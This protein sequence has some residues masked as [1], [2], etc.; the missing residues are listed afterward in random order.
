MDPEIVER[1]NEQ[2]R[3]MADILSQQ[4]ASMAAMVKNMQD[5]ATAAKNQTNATKASGEAFEGVT[6][7]Q[8]AYQQVE[9]RKNQQTERANQTIQRF[10]DAVD[11]TAGAVMTL[12]KT[13]M[14]SNHSFQKYNGILGSVGDTALEVGRN[15]GILGSILGGVVKASTAVLGYQ[16]E[17]ADALLKFNDNISK[18]G[19]AN[20][21]STDTIL[22]MGNAAGFVAKDLEKLSG[23]MQ[24]LGSNFRAIGQG[25]VDSTT[26]FMEMVNVGSEVRQEF[27]RLGYSQEQLVEA[28]AGYIE[29]MGTAGL[30]LRSF[31][32]DFGSLSK[33][34]TDYVKNLQVLSELSGL[35]VEEQQ[36]RMQA[37]AADRQFQLY[38]V[39][40]NKKI[41][42]AG[43]EEE[44]RRLSEQVTFA[45]QAK[46]RITSQLGEEAGRGFGQMLAGQPVT[47][48]IATMALTGTS[49]VV[50]DLAA[51]ARELRLTPEQMARSQNEINNKYIGLVEE[52][53]AFR[54]AVSVSDEFNQ[55]MGGDRAL[56]ENVRL[57][58]FN[59]EQVTKDI[60]DRIKKN[61]E[62]KGPA[63]EDRRQEA[64]NKLTEAEI[65]ARTKVDELAASIGFT[66][67]IVLGLAAAAGIAALALGKLAMSGRGAA[68][69]GGRG[70]GA[71]AGGKGDKGG[72]GGKGGG[73]QPRDARG[74]W[75]T[76]APE[77]PSKLGGMAK[78]AGRVL[79]KLAAPLAIG[80][81]LY[82]AYQGF[83][84]DANASLGQKFKNAGS[85]V[86]GGLTF[87]LLGSNP[88]DIAAQAAQQGNQPPPAPQPEEPQ[89][90]N[91]QTREYV[92]TQFN[93]SVAAFGSV[94]TSFAKTVTAFATTT[95]AFATSTKSFATSTKKLGEIIKAETKNPIL[96]AVVKR[97]TGVDQ[98][99]R[100]QKRQTTLESILGRSLLETEDNLSPLEKFEK[101]IESSTTNLI[102]LRE[103]EL[104]R[105]N[106]NEIS[107][108]QFRISVEDASKKLD[109]ISGITR[110]YGPGGGGGGGGGGGSA[111]TGNV[112]VLDAIAQAEGTYN[113]GYNT[114]LG[115]GAY[116]PGGREMN[117]T[118]MTLSQVLDAQRGMLNHPDNNFNSSAMGRYQ[119]VS[120]TL[121]DAARNLGMDL[122]TT[123]FDQA[124]QD[125]MAM[126]ILEKQGLGAWEG[127]KR[128]PELR[129]RAE[130]AM[131][132]G[133]TTG[134]SLPNP[135]D[136]FQDAFSQT[137]ANTGGIVGLGKQLQSEGLVI[138]GH[139]QFGGRPARGKHARNSRHY[140]DLAI[141]INAPGGITE[142]NDP[143]W[144]NKFNDLAFR[145]QRAGFAVKWNDDANHRD[146][147]HA[148][149]GPSEG[150]IVR[151]AKGGIFDGPKTGY[152][153][154]LHGS[155]M[156]A[157][158]NTNSVLMKL[159]KT[160]AES[161]EVKQV[162]K[163]TSSI[164]KETIEKIFSMNSEMMDT[165]ISK[166]D[167]M[168]EALSD[169]NDTRRK[170]LKNSQ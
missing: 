72:K 67:P 105:H 86:L 92:E 1:L 20:A 60:Q 51:A 42:A 81:S 46:E 98:P 74:R 19:A 128:H 131:R 144:K 165:M 154:E 24:R 100:L 143:V 47:E 139:T 134:P 136:L 63:A 9:E 94:V 156:I 17:Q 54:T 166:L 27:Q 120:T 96:D 99:E 84:A 57:Q 140:K 78:G 121:R 163:P 132:E 159:A 29:L 59:E 55:L 148:S 77:T 34:S 16:L 62:G 44:K 110:D 93:K 85:S 13:V 50:N 21:F 75:T 48:G 109:M 137:Q 87:G 15:F 162:M 69:A 38:L 130:Q 56:A 43:T 155:E 119:I 65:Y 117:L 89:S 28:Q 26:R 37:A 3:E 103:A 31:S 79:G 58:N 127:F 112:G 39:E 151:A 4:N 32:K 152:P 6:K 108:K 90:E 33:L 116:L 149:V 7:K 22:Q 124:T 114:S 66:T 8:Q 95:K 83:G 104:N 160:P 122:E 170:I 158:L 70:S 49:D 126:W 36:K 68:G 153:A 73:A 10:N 97:L 125:R 164:E 168:V 161:E 80:M 167:N 61:E 118:S 64:R 115:H 113:T 41:A 135:F 11:F 141:D 147:I 2:L 25:A 146:H 88:A 91:Q 138:S 150:N 45:M 23:P 129:A 82:D 101:A 30:S 107:M 123:K 12:G 14:D 111:I 40:M 18:M 157:P 142:A 169:G 35:D 76:P 145:I 5:Q 106:L 53:G 71:G 133:P 52:G 102:S